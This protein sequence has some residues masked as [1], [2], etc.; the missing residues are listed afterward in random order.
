MRSN[1]DGGC[2]FDDGISPE[3]VAAIYY[4][5]AN[6]TSAPTTTSSITTD[7]LG[8]CGNDP[9]SNTTALCSITPDPDPPVS[10]NIDIVFGSNGTAFVWFMNNSSFRGDYNS[11][12][13]QDV[14]QN[15]LTFP[16]E[17]NV[18]NF[19]SNSSVRLVIYNNFQFGAHPIHV[20]P[21]NTQNV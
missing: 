12:V 10:Q 9:L 18:Y 7:Q 13:L 19:G 1:L 14:Q 20:G 2:S 16:T 21:P 6:T 17:W 11:P 15:N 5:N 3:A 8:D 4:E